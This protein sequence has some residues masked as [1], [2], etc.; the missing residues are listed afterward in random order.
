MRRFEALLDDVHARGVVLHG[1]AGIGKTRLGEELVATAEQRGWRTALLRCRAA[2]VD[3]HL[4]AFMPL[5]PP[6]LPTDPGTPLLLA[7]RTALQQWIGDAPVLLGLDDVHLIDPT[8]AALLHQLVTS[9]KVR[10]VLTYRSGEWVPDTVAQLWHEGHLDQWEVGPLDPAA[11]QAAAEAMGAP[12]IPPEVAARL[13]EL[14]QGNPLHLHSIVRAVPPGA[15]A[16]VAALEEAAASSPT[17]ADFV[18]S[19]LG[20]LSPAAREALHTVALAEPISLA[21]VEDLVGADALL[22]A[23][24][25]DFIT[26]VEDD[27]RLLVRL[28][29]PLYGEILRRRLSRLKARAIYRSL[30]DAIN[31]HGARRRDDVLRTAVWSV[32]AGLRHDAAV[33]LQA[34]A[35]AMEAFDP[36]LVERLV[37]PVWEQ[38]RDPMAGLLLAYAGYVGGDPER[39]DHHVQEL[40]ALMPDPHL[41]AVVRTLQSDNALFRMGDAERARAALDADGEVTDAR[42]RRELD[43]RR[44][45]LAAFTL[46]REEAEALGE[47][48]LTAGRPNRPTITAILALANLRSASGDP[49]GSL[50]TT[51]GAVE[52]AS[53]AP[54]YATPL[55]VV[56]TARSRPLVMLGRLQEAEEMARLSLAVTVDDG[57]DVNAAICAFTLAWVLLWRGRPR[58]GLDVLADHAPVLQSNH[59]ATFE[60]WTQMTEGLLAAVLGDV[61]RSRR[62]LARVADL[63]PNPVRILDGFLWH[64]R[65]ALAMAEREPERA[66]ELA[67]EAVAVLEADGL[68]FEEGT[69]RHLQVRLGDTSG[70]ERLQ[71][72][73]RAGGLL[74][75]LADH[76]TALVARDPE[77]LGA[78]ADAL[79]EAGA[80]SLAAA[81]AA[82]ASEAHARAGDQRAAR[83]WARRS[84]ELGAFCEHGVVAH[85]PVVA[86]TPLSRR[87]REVAELAAAGLRSRD[88]AE[89]LYLSTRTVDNHLARV[90]DKLGVRS[91]EDLG[92]VLGV[93]PGSA[94]AT[95]S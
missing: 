67:R 8:S 42:A 23:E 14:T 18:Q 5:L 86:V 20:R 92:E 69:L 54:I 12:T 66:R 30:V 34:G 73:G 37:G 94:A 39:L 83:Q 78:A 59:Y 87:E 33:L 16:S 88:I 27:R 72:L 51:E 79:H 22:E 29:H 26:V 63:S 90:Y 49:T 13:H 91:R 53:G 82:D 45:S 77:A 19:R 4:G 48:F 7:A 76:A 41:R 3:L 24:E 75:S 56:L 52:H 58:S 65:V 71:E 85:A 64:G 1:P 80:E 84:T 32:D 25:Q 95:A 9:G 10:A 61:D 89:R 31:A 38:Q 17:M 15:L 50:A 35:R 36:V 74:G 28:T 81:A 21:V 60:R 55:R 40:A 46:Q 2:S 70:L 11:N 93:G 68:A 43:A 44:A 62:A 47:P 57:D 6:D